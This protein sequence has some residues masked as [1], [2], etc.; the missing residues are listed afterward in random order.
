MYRDCSTCFA[1]SAADEF[2]SFQQA[3]DYCHVR[4]GTLLTFNTSADLTRVQRYLEGLRKERKEHWIGYLN[5]EEEERVGE[6]G[7]AAA[8]DVVQDDEN[9][10]TGRASKAHERCIGVKGGQFFTRPCDRLLG[11][12]CE[13]TYS[14]ESA[15]TMLLKGGGAPGV[16]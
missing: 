10:I 14:G 2:L 9:F 8:P 15:C 3:S 16:M 11:F 5:S 1:P 6:R 4:G 13:Y 12:I 7:G